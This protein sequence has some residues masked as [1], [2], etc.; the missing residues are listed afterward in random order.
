MTA[1]TI[2][3]FLRAHPAAVAMSFL[4]ALVAF[5]FWGSRKSGWF[6][7]AQKYRTDRKWHPIGKGPIYSTRVTIDRF[8][9]G[10]TYIVPFQDGVLFY[11]PL[12]S[13]FYPKFLIPWREFRSLECKLIPILNQPYYEAKVATAKKMYVV[14][15]P[16]YVVEYGNKIGVWKNQIQV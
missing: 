9:M 15:L 4:I 13:I 3:S 16:Q 8:Q 14:G 1:N 2:E 12:L 7:I 11:F 5:F 6:D 10:G